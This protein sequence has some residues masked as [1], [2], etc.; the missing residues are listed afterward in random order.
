MKDFMPWYNLLR[1]PSW[2]PDPSVIGT[3]WTILYP[4]IIVVNGYVLYQAIKGRVS[5]WIAAPFLI[6]IVANAAFT[7]IQFGLR[8][9]ALAAIDISII[10]LTIVWA[11]IAIWPHSK[12]VAV[13]FVPYLAWVST[14]SVLQFTITFMNR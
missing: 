11:M 3:I 10:W 9:L 1:K 6:N 7:P 14:A 4:I 2:T 13:A 5:W 12:W 8:N